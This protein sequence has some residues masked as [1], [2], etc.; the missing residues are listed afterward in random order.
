MCLIVSLLMI[1]LACQSNGRDPKNFIESLAVCNLVGPPVPPLLR[2]DQ[3]E[4]AIC[5][6]DTCQKVDPSGSAHFAWAVVHFLPAL[7]KACGLASRFDW[8]LPV[9]LIAD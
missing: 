4:A 6:L 1:I 7:A 3:S 9:V 5:E 8:F 2:H